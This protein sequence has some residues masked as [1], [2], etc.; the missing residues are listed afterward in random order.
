[1]HTAPQQSAGSAD[2]APNA[3]TS[4]PGTAMRLM[5]IAQ[6]AVAWPVKTSSLVRQLNGS[7]RGR[8]SRCWPACPEPVTPFLQLGSTK[9]TLQWAGGSPDITSGGGSAVVAAVAAV[10][11]A[12]VA[13][14]DHPV[15]CFTGFTMPHRNPT[16]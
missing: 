9:V 7:S 15:S 13:S 16:T 14:A 5:A 12:A 2:P 8:R 1:M 11:A 4:N 10:A 3:D 6:W